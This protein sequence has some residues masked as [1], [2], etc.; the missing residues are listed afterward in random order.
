MLRVYKFQKGGV[1]SGSL[2]ELGS[3]SICW[4]DCVNPTKREL[5]DIS[6]KAKIPLN[7]LENVLD[8]EERPKVSDLENYSLI[9]VRTPLIERGEI[10]TSPL[11]V[12][13]SKNKNNIITITLKE[14]NPVQKI[15]Q[16][17]AAK[18]ID[19]KDKGV[20]FFTYRLLDEVLDAY[21]SILDNLE[22]KI[23]KIEDSVVKSPDKLTVQH[24][25]SV[26]KTLIFFHRA[27]TANREV[28]T[29]IEKEYVANIDKK[30][31]KR[32]RAL[33]NDVT[34]LID[35]EGT[36]R[37]ILTGTL[38]IYLSSV[39]NNLGQVMKTLTVI[40]AFVLIPTLISG[41]Y[42]MNFSTDSSYNMPE[43]YWQ[44]GYFFALGLMLI[45]MIVVYIFFR[46]KGW[47]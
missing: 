37:D 40:S 14:V 19:L 2:N 31:I 27:L 10:S 7:E 1:K 6:E 28:I 46:K 29:A 21:F 16:L 5:K 43:L 15:K 9:I 24:I 44:Y 42:G 30:N 18:K 22:E 32:F 41:I 34:Q 25:F 20:S 33:Y 8:E 45:S 13:I 35:T 3:S 17:V 12:F 26:K 39:S 4:A 23:D 36:Y 38:D 11:S 47:M